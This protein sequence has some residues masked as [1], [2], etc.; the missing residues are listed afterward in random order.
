MLKFVSISFLDPFDLRH[1]TG[2]VYL[3]IGVGY[4]CFTENVSG[5][6]MK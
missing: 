5:L 4:L 1:W 6:E 2:D 3:I